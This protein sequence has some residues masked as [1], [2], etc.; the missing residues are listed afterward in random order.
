MKPILVAISTMTK[1]ELVD[2]AHSLIN[3]TSL[4][5]KIDSD[6]ESVGGDI[7]LSIITKSEGFIWVNRINLP[8]YLL[9]PHILN[10]K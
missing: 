8:N 9:N 5:R 6:I 3:V 4:R 2:M 1:K 10:M 7:S